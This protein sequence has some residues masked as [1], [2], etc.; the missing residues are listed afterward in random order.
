[1]KDFPKSPQVAPSL[2]AC[3]HGNFREGV[4][5][6]SKAKCKILHIDVM[7][8]SFVP[9]ITFGDNIVKIAKEEPSLFLD[10]HLM[11]VNPEKHFESMVEA[12]SDNIT[13]H[14]KVCSD[15]PDAAAKLKKLNVK[16][17]IA[18]N[19]EIPAKVIL[20]H[21]HLFD[22]ALVMTVNP[23]WGGQKFI[24]EGLDKIKVIKDKII[25]DKLNCLIE[26]DGGVNDITGPKCLAA[27]ADI[28]VSGSYL[29]KHPD[30][31]TAI[32]SILGQ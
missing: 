6:A 4:N 12:G 28:L 10:T 22:L 11:I 21:L 5:F 19:P 27:G 16:A 24:E 15:I 18:I 2:L 20:P 30:S 14:A 9:P 1:M 31:P 8:G 7:D 26:V 3:D 25:Q 29:Y 32:S 23:G 17:G 13:F